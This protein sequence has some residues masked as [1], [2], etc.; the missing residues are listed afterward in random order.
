MA[1][2]P[3]MSEKAYAASKANTYVIQVPSDANKMTVAAAVA[4]QFDVTVEDVRIA[5]IKG[6]TKKA[7][8]KGGK[9]TVGRRNDVKKAFV[10]IKA[11]EKINIFGEI[12]EAEKQAAKDAEKAAKKTAK[13]EAKAE[14]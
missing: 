5:I 3:R 13:K 12:E 10:R 8:K 7:Y 9:P 14:K 4:A 2:K 1:L 11:G 6:K